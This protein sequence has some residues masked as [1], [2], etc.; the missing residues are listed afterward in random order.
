MGNLSN[1]EKVEQI[2]KWIVFHTNDPV[3]NIRVGEM[4]DDLLDEI[5]DSISREELEYKV[6]EY[7]EN[8]QKCKEDDLM[9]IDY[10]EDRIKFLEELIEEIKSKFNSYR[11]DFE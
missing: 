8:I 5:Y 4:L 11:G 2:A 9:L 1:E 10:Y 6:I 7:R 3:G